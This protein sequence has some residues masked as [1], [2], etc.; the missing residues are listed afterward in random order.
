LLV[1]TSSDVQVVAR[2]L[3]SEAARYDRSLR[4]EA[5][6]LVDVLRL[7]IL[8]SRVAAIGATIL[9]AIALAMASIGI[10]GVIAYTVS[11]RTKEIGVRVALGADPGNV[12]RM[13]LADGARVVSAGI[14]L[15]LGGAVVMTRLIASVLPT[16]SA[17]DVPAFT[18]AVT[19]I[20]AVGMVACYLPART[21]AAVDPL[22]ALRTE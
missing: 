12:R 5:L 4:F 19:V 18:V 10:Y 8:P 17:F 9:G 22:V 15:G 16:A 21:A 1:R 14:G 6:P 7:W 20:A 13:V 2:A 3:R 11:Q